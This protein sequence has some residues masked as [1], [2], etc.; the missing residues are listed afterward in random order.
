MPR[1]LN[2]YEIARVAGMKAAQEEHQRLGTS[3]R[4]R[5]PV[6]DVIEDARI[7][8]FFQPMRTLYGA[9]D[10]HGEA[11]GII[12]NSQHPLSLQRFTAGHEYGHHVLGHEAS[13]DDEERIYR[14]DRQSML[15]VAAQA[16]AGEFLMPIQLVNYS[17]RAMELPVQYPAMTSSQIYQL[18]LEL[19][20]SYAAVVT[21]LVG[22]RKL[23]IDGG[24]RLRRLSPLDVKTGLAGDKP[25]DSWADVWLL[26]EAQDGRQIVSRLRD[27]IHV[28]LPET[29]ST[30]YV[31]DLVDPAAGVVE[32]V[33]DR[34]ENPYGREHIGAGGV[35]HI[36]LRVATPGS[37]RI[38]LELRRPWQADSPP[39]RTFQTALDALAPI[40]GDV[41]AGVASGQKKG[42]IDDFRFATA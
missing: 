41:T 1:K 25:A 13:A 9:Y 30:G 15:E 11:A 38:R 12:I 2:A 40:T 18:A 14:R 37:G 6:F 39:V 28:R 20:V 42:V 34:F 7:W 3:M 36:W 31:W 4:E 29:P 23:S 26:D 16:F 8:L 32:V 10:R 24:R 33:A 19:G 27:E 5:V 21:Q 17:L 35:R 22:Q